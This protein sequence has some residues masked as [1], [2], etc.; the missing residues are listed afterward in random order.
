VGMP[1]LAAKNKTDYVALAVA[2]AHDKDRL[3]KLRTRL[4]ERLERSVLMDASRF[5]RQMES[6]YRTIWHQWC[7]PVPA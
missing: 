6:A 1:E 3:R 5:A 4:R 2:L 7:K